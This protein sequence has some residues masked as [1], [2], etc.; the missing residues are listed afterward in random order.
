M[1]STSNG[2]PLED[3]LLIARLEDAIQLSE[4]YAYPRFVG[5]L[6]EGQ[7]A[8]AESFLRR[9]SGAFRFYGGHPEAER[10]F[11]GVFPSCFEPEEALFPLT[12]LGL[13]FRTGT[14]LSHRD[15]LG[16]L[17]SCGIRREKIGDILCGDG[18]AVVFVEEDLAPYLAEQVTKVGGEGV[19]V[20]TAYVGE[21]PAAHTYRLLRDTVASPRLDAVVKALIGVSREEAARLI[22]AGLVM[23]NHRPVEAVA[24]AIHEG[25]CLSIRGKGRFLVDELHTPT[26][27]GR[28][29]MVARQCV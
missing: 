29:V 26:R 11:C 23:V 6:D 27:K 9:R 20:Q 24:A 25:D 2:Q 16:T 10:T 1:A 18:L 13:H 14:G 17:L 12:A 22:T 4:A 3:R 7:R 19:T 5:F 15:V 21:L 8:V 28:L